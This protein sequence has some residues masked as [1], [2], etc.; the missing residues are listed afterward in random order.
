[1]DFYLYMCSS[2][3]WFHLIFCLKDGCESQ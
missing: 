2:G 1:M 3:M